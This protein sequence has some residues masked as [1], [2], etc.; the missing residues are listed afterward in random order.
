M[1]QRREFITDPEVKSVRRT[2]RYTDVKIYTMTTG[3][4]A[5]GRLRSEQGGRKDW[6]VMKRHIRGRIDLAFYLFNG[7]DGQ[8]RRLLVKQL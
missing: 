6:R 2:C 5:T 1:C 7:Q 8:G 3:S 4:A